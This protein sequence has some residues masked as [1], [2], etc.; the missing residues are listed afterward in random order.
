MFCLLGFSLA[1]VELKEWLQTTAST[2]LHWQAMIC[3]KNYW[4]FLT[5]IYLSPLGPDFL[6]FLGRS[7]EDFFS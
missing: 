4:I 3:T 2:K 6:N 1:G 7:L 5:Q